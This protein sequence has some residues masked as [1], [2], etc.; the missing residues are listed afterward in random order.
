MVYYMSK[1]KYNP[2]LKELIGPDELYSNKELN[3]IVINQL[4]LLL[5][6]FEVKLL[7]MYFGLTGNYP[8]SISEI[9]NRYEVTEARIHFIYDKSIK[10]LKRFHKFKD[11]LKDFI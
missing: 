7:I 8:W 11:N 4:S 5:R 10:K 3:K 9:A 1:I 2:F 6:P